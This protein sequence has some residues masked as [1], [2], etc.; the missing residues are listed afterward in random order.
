VLAA[1]A[2]L[3]VGALHGL[4][5]SWTVALILL[6]ALVVPQTLV[7]LAA[8]RDRQLSPPSPT[9]PPSASSELAAR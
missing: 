5:G 2:P 9:P 8:G 6:L 7:G 1:F 4:T 3:A